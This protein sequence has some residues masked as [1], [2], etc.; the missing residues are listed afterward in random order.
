[1]SENTNYCDHPV[2]DC[3]ASKELRKDGYSLAI[4]A[5]R[6]HKCRVLMAPFEKCDCIPNMDKV[7]DWLDKHIKSVMV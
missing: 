2:G 4:K 7:A 6:E 5:L 3:I 1:M